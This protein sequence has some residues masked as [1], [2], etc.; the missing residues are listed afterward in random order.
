M[1]FGIVTHFFP[2]NITKKVQD[3]KNQLLFNLK[4]CC[5]GLGSTVLPE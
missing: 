5:G 1:L 4:L 2:E 3:K